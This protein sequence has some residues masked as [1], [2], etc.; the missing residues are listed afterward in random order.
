MI[1]ARRGNLI[2]FGLSNHNM[3]RLAKGQPIKF[4]LSEIMAE[5]PK[6]IDIIIMNGVTED[7][8]MLSLKQLITPSN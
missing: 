2:I 1:K 3:K 4:K 7:S 6:D 8:I 5:A